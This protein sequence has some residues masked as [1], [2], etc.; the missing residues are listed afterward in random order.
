MAVI[1]GSTE[2][3]G[4]VIGAAL[5]TLL[6]EWLKDLLPKV[7]EQSGNFEIVVFGLLV[8]ALLHRTRDGLVPYFARLIPANTQSATAGESI[9][10][11]AARPTSGGRA[12]T[13]AQARE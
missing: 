8:I 2:L 11:A 1:G 12:A 9:A 3:W 10:A 5:L 7:M 4:A 13:A 6:K